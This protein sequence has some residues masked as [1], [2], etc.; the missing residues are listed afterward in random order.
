VKYPNILSKITYGSDLLIPVAPESCNTDYSREEEEA[1]YGPGPSTS[2]DPDFA[3]SIS[4]NQ[5]LITLSEPNDLVRDLN[6][7]FFNAEI[8]GVKITAVE[9]SVRS[10]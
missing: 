3:Q 10:C 4:T 8:L 6:L 9:S 5:H 2:N 7:I 1:V